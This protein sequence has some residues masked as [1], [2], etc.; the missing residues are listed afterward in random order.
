MATSASPLSVGRS[1]NETLLRYIDT[2]FYLRDDGL[3]TERRRRLLEDVRLLPEPLL[4]PVLPY[5]GVV[6]AIEACREVGLAQDEASWLVHGLF[7]TSLGD[8]V[9][10]RRH[11]AEA[12]AVAFAVAGPSNPVVTSG[13]G[14]GKTES[15]LLPVLARLLVEARSWAPAQGVNAWWE[16]SRWSPARKDEARAAAVRTMVLYPTNALVEDQMSR[17]RR[18]ARRIQDLGGPALWFG[19]YTSGAPGGTRLPSTTRKDEK[20]ATV[21]HDL[22][23]L[24]QEYEALASDPEVRDFLPDP[25]RAEL[26]TRWDMICDPPDVLVTNYSMLNV[27]LMRRLEDPIFEQTRAWLE[28]DPANVFTLVVD[29]LH[30]YRGTQGSEVALIVRNLLMRLG[31]VPDSPQLRVIGTSASLEG[32]RSDYLERFFGVPRSTFKQISGETRPVM[33]SLPFPAPDLGSTDAPTMTHV[34]AEACRDEDG[35]VRATDLPT[36]ATRAFGPA[37]S[38]EDVEKALEIIAGS[39]DEGRIPFRAH[40]FMRTMRGMWACANPACTQVEGSEPRERAGIGRL[41]ARPVHQCPCGG[42]VLEL[43]Y[44]GKCG[45]GSLGGHVVATGSGGQFLGIDASDSEL[46]RPKFLFERP[47]HEYRWYSPFSDG[48]GATWN[49][50]GPKKDVEFRF[51]RARFDPV[52]GFIET[53]AADDATG[54]VVTAKNPDD[55]FRPPALPSRCPRCL[56]TRHQTEFTSGRVASALRAHTQGATQAAQLLVAEI[57]RELGDEQGISRTIVFTDSRDDA[58]RMSVGLSMNHY[59]DLVRQEIDQALVAPVED[60]A[61]ILREGLAGRLGPS[62]AARLGELVQEHPQMVAAY[63]AISSGNATADQI[64]AVDEF[65]RRIAAD[66]SRP[67]SGLVRHLSRQ[68]VSLGVPPGGPRASRLTLGDSRTP[69]FRAFEPPTVGLWTPL[70]DATERYQHQK[71]FDAYMATSVAEALIG[72]SRAARDAEDNLVAYVVPRDLADSLD[73]LRTTALC[74][75]LRIFLSSGRWAPQDSGSASKAAILPRDVVDYLRRTAE[76]VGVSPEE[77]EADFE[78]A[79]EPM[80]AGLVIDLAGADVPLLVV[81]GADVVWICTTCGQRHLHASA[82]TCVRS[83]CSGALVERSRVELLEEDYYAWLATQRPQRLAVAE[84]T[85]QT[86]PPEEQRRR[87][88]VFRGA[89][90]PAPAENPLTSPLDV[91]SVTTTMEVG[92]D[93]GSLRSTVMGNMPP[94]R[95]NYQQ[96]VGRAGRKGQAFSFAATLC[97]DRSHDDYYFANSGRITGDPPPQPFLDTNRPKI[98]KR[99]V[100]AELLR[101]ACRA[102][103]SPPQLLRESVHGAFGRADEWNKSGQEDAPPMRS[104]IEAWLKRAPDVD[105]VV[106]RLAAHTGI[107]AS[108]VDEIVEW[109]REGLVQ[110]IDGVVGSPVFTQPALSERLANA[111]VLPMFGFP[112]RVRTLYRTGIDNRLT[113]DEISDRPLDQAVSLFA[114]GAEVV[115]DGWVYTVNGFASVYRDGRGNVRTTDPIRSSFA[116]ERCAVCGSS[117]IK[118]GS[119]AEGL[120][121]GGPLTCPVCAGDI[122]PMTVYQPA[123]FRTHPKAKDGELSDTQ[124]ATASRPVLEWTDLGGLQ[125]DRSGAMDIWRLEDANLVTVNDNRRAQFDLYRHSDHSVIVPTVETDNIS[126]PKVGKGGIGDVRTTDAA[127]LLIR[128]ETLPGE[129]IAT[130]VAICPSGPAAM[131]SFAEALRRGAQAELDIDPDELTVGL[132]PRRHVDGTRTSAV[133]VADT[134]ENGAGYALELAGPRMDDVVRQIADGETGRGWN[135]PGHSECDSSCPDCLRSWDNRHL[136]PALDWRLALD[137]AD[138]AMGRDLRLAR[139]FDLVPGAVSAFD[140]GFRSM[141]E[142]PY[143]VEIVDDLHVLVHGNRAVV[144]GHPLWSRSVEHETELQRSVADGLKGRGMTVTWSDA[145]TL[146]NRGVFVA[147]ALTIGYID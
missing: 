14:S 83:G 26:L 52:T 24:V 131:L 41:F 6:D 108:M 59:N 101:R 4:E 58:A 16:T 102:L 38:V 124:V 128:S 3:R 127:L 1:I 28:F 43:I 70:P 11:Q 77:L 137:V 114:P 7:G 115:S 67:W 143:A 44:C 42:R 135:A 91:L 87:Q 125:P 109:A 5:D 15:F 105:D 47:E 48:V 89:L 94:K 90:K 64:A 86:R 81:P 103:P 61:M 85:G 82:R 51:A 71:Q 147:K 27:M 21:G 18:T 112:T 121:A 13:T 10:L 53:A 88:R 92:V 123:G 31:L 25:R 134:L 63:V 57:F 106:R 35:A 139:W 133:Y 76:V 142:Q 119:A 33:A 126:M 22:R 37:G 113:L 49:H 117:T 95:F 97:R 98:L 122:E 12:L 107:E 9:R 29:E 110:D 8:D 99:V 136:H 39:S 141:F 23:L 34:L 60:I 144:I 80:L 65:E 36:I 116:L 130:D 145:R 17:L 79:L 146:R 66:R 140:A 69:W 118:A 45:E 73:D 84:L 104:I 93:I 111:G 50:G 2:A 138:L 72:T 40:Y 46:D 20:V 78:Q 129:V 96:R 100:A 68:L 132:Q 54:V 62:Q 30:L 55:E 120:P 19:R 56:H 75:A 32:D 74:S